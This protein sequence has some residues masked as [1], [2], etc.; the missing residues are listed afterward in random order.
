VTIKALRL[1]VIVMPSGCTQ[2]LLA[3]AMAAIL[4]TRALRPHAALVAG[5]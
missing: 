5:V 4:E 2:N 3:E 1:F